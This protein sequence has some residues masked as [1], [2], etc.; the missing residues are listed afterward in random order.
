M[1]IWITSNT[2]IAAP[3]FALQM[4]ISGML[5][6]SLGA[7]GLLM[8]ASLSKWIRGLMS[9]GY[10]SGDFIRLRYG[11]TVWRLFPTIFLCYSLGWLVSMGIA[12]G[13]LINSLTGIPYIMG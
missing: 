3:Q 10:T 5:G 9:N 2:I 6:Y 8:F 12:G 7:A 11:K 1:T 13:I 4:G